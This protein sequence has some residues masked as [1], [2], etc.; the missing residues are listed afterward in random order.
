M[1]LFGQVKKLDNVFNELLNAYE[2]CKNFSLAINSVAENYRPGQEVLAYSV[3]PHS[4][5]FTGIFSYPFA[6]YYFPYSFLVFH[7]NLL[8]LHF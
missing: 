7:P 4:I 8:G 2:D 3:I 6:G 5:S 1:Y